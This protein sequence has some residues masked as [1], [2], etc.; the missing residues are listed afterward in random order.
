MTARLSRV[1]FTLAQFQSIIIPLLEEA[2][3]LVLL[4]RYVPQLVQQDPERAQSLVQVVDSLPLA[5]TLMGKYLASPA[6]DGHPWPLKVAL[7]QLH[8]IQED[9]R[10]SIQTAHE[11]GWPNLAELVPLS[12]YAPI[13][14]CDQQLSPQAQAA[15]RT[16]AIFPPKPQSFSEEAALAI[17]QQP[18]ETLDELC[19]TG[20]L[21]YWGSGR[22]SLHQTIA[23]YARARR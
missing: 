16:L 1:A 5:L 20:L 13:A 9:L 8:D 18:R 11:E 6:F 7:A 14:I 2:D 15:L 3:G 21:E 23:D 19:V 17:S 22:Y 4:A 12:L 10:L